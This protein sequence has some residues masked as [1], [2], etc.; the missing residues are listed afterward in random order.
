MLAKLLEQSPVTA[1]ES[2]IGELTDIPVPLRGIFES[3]AGATL[4]DGFTA[5]TRSNPRGVATSPPR[6]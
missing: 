1:R 5:F 3:V 2:E 4:A 6:N